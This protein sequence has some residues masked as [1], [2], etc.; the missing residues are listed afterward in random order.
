MLSRIPRRQGGR[1]NRAQRIKG[2]EGRKVR[3]NI[4][5]FNVMSP[6]TFREEG[7]V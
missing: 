2:Q 3:G 1:V 7:V 6:F 5:F 4:V